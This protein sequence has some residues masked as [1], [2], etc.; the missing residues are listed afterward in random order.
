MRRPLIIAVSTLALAACQSSQS[1]NRSLE[2]LPVLPDGKIGAAAQRTNGAIAPDTSS[3]AAPQL[4]NG[5]ASTYAPPR[6]PAGKAVGD[7]TLTFADT[8]IR[9]VVRQILGD[10][11]QVNYTIDP[12]VRGMATLETTRP[13]GRDEILPTLQTLLAAN[14]ATLVQSG[15]L[16]RVVPT[17]VTAAMPSLGGPGASGTEILP[18]RYASAKD[19]AKVMEPFISEGGRVTADI[20][21]NALIVTGDPSA[22]QTLISL[23]RTFD[24][25]VLAGQSYAIFPV[26]SGEPGKM[27]VELQKVLQT[28]GDGALSGLVKVIP[29]E[30]VNGVLVVSPQKRYIDEAR[31]FFGI[32]DQARR[33]NAR[34]WHVYYVQNGQSGDLANLLQR[35]FTPGNVSAQASGPGST[36]PGQEQAQASSGFNNN[37]GAGAGGGLNTGGVGGGLGGGTQTGSTTSAGGTGANRGEEASPSAASEALSEPMESGGN[38]AQAGIRILANKKN[39]AILI[40]STPEEQSTIEAM[41][42]KIDI[43]PLQVRIDATIAEVTLNDNLSYGTQFFFRN[44]GLNGI[45]SNATGSGS[46]AST[47][48]VGAGGLPTQ[49]VSNLPG[50]ILSKGTGAIRYALDALQSVTNVRVLSS[51]QVVV[52]DNEPAR[53]QVGNLVPFLSQS[54]TSTT[55]AGA[56]IVNSVDYRETGVILNVTPRVNAGGLVTLDISQEVSDVQTGVTTAGLNSPT[57]LQRKI[58]SRVVVQDGQTIGLAG[59]IRDNVSEGNS[60][61]PLLKDIPVLGSLFSQQTNT[62]MKTELLVMITPHVIEDQ[63][64]ARA[65]TEDLRNKLLNAGLVPQQLLN[66]PSSG[67][68]NP[69]APLFNK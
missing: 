30:R 21:R 8:D 9:E 32:A 57:F 52:L 19:L 16:Y 26:G 15:T 49:F 20:T 47:I 65:L 29:M 51:P 17:S 22:R 14:G 1:G 56:P 2:P 66:L 25:D 40:Y 34:A 42:A 38:G 60:G 41:L 44:G 69:N 13:L 6:L 3:L 36:S 33:S 59:L 31:R 67:S 27:A 24:I 48:T 37:G 64:D 7:T 68:A 62:R 35:A 23:I 12:A 61:I 63:R 55:Q 39:N 53:L 4:D 58:K 11:L 10:I 43:L 50:F 46:T 5:T 18:L 54:A 28:E 45:L